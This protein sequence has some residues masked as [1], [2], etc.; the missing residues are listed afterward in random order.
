LL[1]RDYLAVARSTGSGDLIADAC[2]WQVLNHFESGQLDDLEALLD[3]Y[4][5]LSAARSGLHQYQ[6]GA[7][8]ITLA[9]LRGNWPN[10][11]QRIEGLLDIGM[12]TRREDAEG[13]Y[14][15]Q[16]FALNRDRG[17]LQALAPQL[18]AMAASRRRMW[19]P[20]LMLLYVE[21]GLHAEAR[22]IFDRLI[23]GDCHAISRD[24][25]YVTCLVFCAQACCAL[26]DVSGAE[27]LYER[28]L[29]YA[30]QAANHP[31][32]VCFGA[33][34]LYLAELACTANRQD[35]ALAHFDAALRINRAM[36]AWPSLARTL[37]K[38]GTFL[39]AQQS[40]SQ[41]HLGL[42]QLREA[43]QLAR[44]LEMAGLVTDI[45][46]SLHRS[47]DDAEY[48]D[49]LTLREVEVLRLLAIGRTNKDVSLVLAISLNT[50]A[51]HVRSILNKT[52]CAN[53]TEAAAYAIRHGLQ[54]MPSE[55]NVH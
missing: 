19:E 30:G 5:G 13:V 7:H 35:R 16:M 52:R 4:G 20:G 38:Y 14:G 18:K 55:A 11:E 15:A 40:D 10:L 29:P 26:G 32:A 49:E 24:D 31:T 39:L 51:T 1:G 45:E 17:R 3:H 44:R 54:Q 33:A 6:V 12:K 22:A 36:C 27:L 23:R 37:F 50:V 42:Q 41:R 43:D 48:P 21:I 9:L 25:M 47:E 34:D 8:R 53:R 28:L 2:H 46:D